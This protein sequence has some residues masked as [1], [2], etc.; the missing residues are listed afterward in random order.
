MTSKPDKSV[1]TLLSEGLAPL[2]GRRHIDSAL[3]E[4]AQRQV[5]YPSSQSS[6][7]YATT[8]IVCV[9][10]ADAYDLDQPQV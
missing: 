3:I 8:H 6:N 4:S 2:K 1:H 7:G 5:I 9:N 10:G